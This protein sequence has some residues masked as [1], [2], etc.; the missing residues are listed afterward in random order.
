MTPNEHEQPDLSQATYYAA[1]RGESEPFRIDSDSKADWALRRIAEARGEHRRISAL[2]AE[3]MAALGIKQAAEDDRLE[4]A[5]AWL[6]GQL[7]A[8]FAALPEDAAHNTKTQSTYRLLS[9]TLKL[10]RGRQDFREGAGL[11]A[12]A[13]RNMPG[14]VQTDEKVRWGELKRSLRMA[15]DGTVID[16]GTGLVVDGVEVVQGEDKFTVETEAA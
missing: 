1:A 6:Q 2:I 8:Y 7:E 10:R 13:K 14:M 9:G 12:W 4:R 15:E 5:T 3:Q 16:A 11:L